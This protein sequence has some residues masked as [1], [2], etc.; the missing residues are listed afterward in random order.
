MRVP[1]YEKHVS[2][3][4]PSVR[5]GVQIPDG[6]AGAVTRPV[7][8]GEGQIVKGLEA[9]HLGLEARQEKQDQY[10]LAS[11]V[12]EF[13]RANTEYLHARDGGV[14]SKKGGQTFGVSEQ[15]DQYA[16][17]TMDEI[18]RRYKMNDRVR[19]SFIGATN[20][21]R[22][23]SLSS[24]MRY[25]QHETDAA[26]ELEWKTMA[27]ET[28]S[29]AAL[30][31]SDDT[32]F[33]EELNIGMGAVAQQFAPYG[34]TVVGQKLKEFASKCQTSRV[35]AM[36]E[37]DPRAAE[38]YLK[39]YKSEF[40][41]ADFLRVK[42]AVD[43]RMDV[44]RVQETTDGLARRF[45]SESAALAHVRRHYEGDMENKLVAAVKTRFGE[46]RIA[47]NDA[48]KTA[49]QRQNDAFATLR[50]EYW[51][52]GKTVPQTQLETMYRS[53]RLSDSGYDSALKYNRSLVD[54]AGKVRW[55]QDH[56]E[57][58]G[59]L[60]LEQQDA[61]IQELFGY[62]RQER[63]DY[64][65]AIHQKALF[66]ELGE[67]DIKLGYNYGLIDSREKA[68]AEAMLKSVKAA[69]KAEFALEQK[70][71]NVLLKGAG[72]DAD[73]R[74]ETEKEAA[75]RIAE[76]N[77]AD[78]DYRENGRRII[79]SAAASA[80]SE[81]NFRPWYKLGLG[82]KK[83]DDRLRELNSRAREAKPDGKNAALADALSF[84]LPQDAAP[85]SGKDPQIFADAVSALGAGS[86]PKKKTPPPPD[87]DDEDED[88]A[89]ISL[90]R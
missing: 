19:E 4:I 20:A 85:A 47:R 83:F 80:L 70:R 18:V 45:D 82:N 23:S 33:N 59:A 7:D 48:E 69:D 65:K 42:K 79:L 39:K 43:D 27:D 54:R 6:A 21:L 71:V 67:D 74:M 16:Q 26:R 66:G 14:F 73:A 60:T 61:K 51:D 38:A 89:S 57:N 37:D 53:G 46:M 88:A 24:V 68:K 75:A 15:Y 44:L 1:T 2:P 64:A 81:R 90:S 13:R 34:D 49:A 86:A 17:T 40:I 84:L 8:T 52:N 22:D 11:A 9:L 76:M 87:R 32:A 12:N 78:P 25:E 41:G 36:L 63:E 62:T 28:L 72:L 30:C 55:A 50:K 58:W 31:Y 56:I 3:Q 5:S 77:P 35:A 10:Q 29:N